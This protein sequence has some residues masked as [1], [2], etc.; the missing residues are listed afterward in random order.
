MGRSLVTHLIF[1]ETPIE[2]VESQ[3]SAPVTSLMTQSEQDTLPSQIEPNL[4]EED[5]IIILE[6]IEE[7]VEEPKSEPKC[8]EQSIPETIETP[9]K[10]VKLRLKL[11]LKGSLMKKTRKTP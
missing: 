6:N 2:S 5:E 8:E 1:F 4:K 10:G 7:L 11:L 3:D 9:I